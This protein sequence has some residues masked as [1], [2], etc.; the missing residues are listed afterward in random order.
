[1]GHFKSISRKKKTKYK[2]IK[3]TIIVLLLIYLVN[4]ISRKINLSDKYLDYLTYTYLGLDFK[5]ENL[6]PQDSLVFEQIDD[7]PIVYIYNTHQTENYKYDKLTSYNIDYSVM[8]AS[9]ILSSYLSD[10]DINS[11]VETESMSKVL[12]NNNL[13]YADSYKASRILLENSIKE[14]PTLK[15][16]IDLHRDSSIYEKTT[17]ELNGKKYVKIMFVIGVEHDN[18]LVNKSFA[19]LLNEKLISISPCL[20]RGILEKSKAT[21]NGIYNQDFNGNTLLLEVGGQYNQIDEVNNTLKILA[22]ILSEYIKE[23]K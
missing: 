20:S 1:M 22:D 13:T 17:C 5:K 3:I 23:N 15:Y 6:T 11:V 8:F 16:F 10:Y 7:D 12:Q 19:N 2:I 4:F 9:Y 21:G 18:Y 14:N